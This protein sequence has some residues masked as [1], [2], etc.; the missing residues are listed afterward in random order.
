MPINRTNYNALA[1]DDGS[2]TVGSLWTKGKVKTVVLDPIDAILGGAFAVEDYGAVGDGATDDHVAIQAAITAATAVVGGTV[3]L[4]PKTYVLGTVGL[5]LGGSVSLRGVSTATVLT[6]SGTGS[7]IT[8]AGWSG[9]VVSDF[10]LHVTNDAGSGIEVGNASRVA[11]IRNVL[12][13]GS[14]T[15]TC[16]G[17]GLFLNAGN[18]AGA[19]SGGLGVRDCYF[20]QSKFGVK[21]TS[22]D[23]TV[24]TWT[25]VDL[26]NCWAVGRTTPVT[27]G[28]GLYFDALT[29][30]GGVNW[31]GGL[32]EYFNYGLLHIQGGTGGNLITACEGCTVYA[33]VGAS[34]AG[35]IEDTHGGLCLTQRSY[36]VSTTGVPAFQ[37]QR[38]RGTGPIDESYYAPNLVVYDAS[39]LADEVA[40]YRG[41]SLINGGSPTKHFAVGMGTAGDF[42]PVRTYIKLGLNKMGWAAAA[43]TTGTWARGDVVWST[44]VAA[45]GVPGWICVTA[46]TPGTWKAMAVVAA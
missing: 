8:I 29:N 10:F 37:R 40:W 30:G 34:F 42:D 22:A 12:I 28:A 19:F 6:Y 16:T 2:N 5:T 38:L 35:V 13:Q 46:G 39:T 36:G 23:L 27:G 32:I 43:P 9:A 15:A 1:D 4:G 20:L 17:A 24:N 11:L 26:T 41:A 44:V 14:G 3:L 21:F 7:A 33:Q 45:Q 25:A 31:R 18:A